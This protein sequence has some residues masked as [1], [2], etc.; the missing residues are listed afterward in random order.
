VFLLQSERP[1]FAPCTT[2]ESPGMRLGS[3][4][5]PNWTLHLCSTL[6]CRQFFRKLILSLI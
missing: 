1:S 4:L 6:H 5:I 2:T 3:N